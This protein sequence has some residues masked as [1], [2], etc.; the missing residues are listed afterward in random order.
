MST[1]Q[2]VTYEVA[3]AITQSDTLADPA[4]PFAALFTGAGGTIKLTTIQN[5]TVTLASVAAGIILPIATQRVWSSTTTA[6]GLIGLQSP[7]YL[8]PFNPGSGAVY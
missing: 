1:I 6:T 5:Q 8:T 2:A 3:S 7:P 4:G